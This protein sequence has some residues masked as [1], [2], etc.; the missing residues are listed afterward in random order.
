VHRAH[1]ARRPR[2][3][4]EAD[5]VASLFGL[6]G[7]ARSTKRRHDLAAL[8]VL[9]LGAGATGQ[10][11]ALVRP[12][13]VLAGQGRVEVILRRERRDGSWRERSVTVLSAYASLLVE[14]ARES[15]N[16]LLGGGRTRHSRVYDLCDHSRAGRWP[17]RLEPA[18]LRAT[19]LAAIATE[20][21]TVLELLDRAGVST[22]EVF[23]ELLGHLRAS[24]DPQD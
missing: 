13:D 12:S 8:M 1:A 9:G 16:W 23:D 15:G 20:P 21:N 24:R 7:Q 18:R 4:Y 10:E 17:L 6:A 5:E 2:P 14:L 11:A 3:P 19:Y 22:F